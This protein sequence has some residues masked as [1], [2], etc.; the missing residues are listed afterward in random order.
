MPAPG[1][2]GARAGVGHVVR[3]D[4]SLKADVAVIGMACRFPHARDLSALWRLVLDGEVAFEDIPKD[5]WNHAAFYEP[6]D[7]RAADKTYVRKGAF[8]EGVKDFA[9]LHY[10]LAPRR[11]QVTDPQHRLLVEMSRQALQ[12]AGYDKR[13][14][15][16][17]G[18]GVYVGISANEFRD[19]MASRTRAM[20]MAGGDFG[21][22]A[23]GPL[24]DALL[25][26]TQDV[27]PIRAFSIAGSLLN[28]AACVVSQTFDL[29]G[30]AFAVDTACSSALT[31]IHQ[32]ALQLRT[33]ECNLALAGGAYLNLVPDNLVGFARIGAISP[34]GACRP[35]D[36]RADGFVMGEGVGVVVLKRLEDALKDGDRIWAVLKGSGCNN[37]G[38]GEGPMTPRPEGQMDAMAR[39]WR[40][41]D[42]GV[43]SV[44]LV[45]THGT[46]TTVGDVV[47]V[48]ALRQFFAQQ[49]GHPVDDTHCYLSSIK[50]NIGHTMSAAGVA[51]FIKAVLAVHHGVVPPQPGVEELNPKLDLEHSPF[52]VARAATAWRDGAQPRRA[53]V[54][55]FG[56]GGTNVH[57]VLEESPHRAA[58]RAAKAVEREL[59]ELVLVSAPRPE[60]LAKHLRELAATVE[61]EHPTVGE[62]ARTLASRSGQDTRLAF[63]ARNRQE[64]LDGF[65]ACADALERGAPLPPGTWYQAQALPAEQRKAVFLFPG[66]GA[67][68]VG[69]LEDAVRRW[70][71]LRDRLKALDAG[72][73]AET[74][75]S[76][77]DALYPPAGTDLVAAQK[78]L[79]RTEVCQPAM[80]ALGITFAEALTK[81]GVRPALAL[82]HSLGEFTAASAAGMLPGGAAVKLVAMRGQAMSALQL[83][84]AG[85]MLAVMAPRQD[86]APLLDGLE[87]VWVANDNH[88]TQVVLSGT[89][90]GVAKAAA[91]LSEK[92]LKTTPLDVSHAF[93]SP[94]MNDVDARMRPLV[95]ALPV[96]D[97]EVQVVSCITARPYASAEEAREVWTRHATS[98][99]DFVGALRTCVEHG[100]RVFVQVGAGTALLSFARGVAPQG[101]TFLS[102]GAAEGGE[103]GVKLL[104]ALGQLFALGF[105]VDPQALLAAGPRDYVPLPPSLLE[106]ETYWPIERAAP[107]APRATLPGLAAAPAAAFP[108]PDAAAAPAAALTLAPRPGAPPMNDLVALFREQTALLQSHAEVVKA[109]AQALAAL[110]GGTATT[111][112]PAASPAPAL[113]SPAAAAPAALPAAP[114]APKA[115]N[116]SNLVAP[117]AAAATPAPEPKAGPDAAELRPQVLE[118]VMASVA[119]IS[120]FPVATLKPEQSL[121]GELGFDSLMLV[122]LDGDV[123]K[124]W[125][126]LGGLPRELFSKSTSVANIVDHVVKALSGPAPAAAAPTAAQ[127]PKAPVSR[128]LPVVRPAPLRKATEA[129]TRFA[130]PLLVTSDAL[131]V[132]AK[133]AELLQAQGVAAQLGTAETKGDFGG[134]VYT[135]SLSRSADWK[136]P[137]RALLDL[138]KRFPEGAG[139][140]VALTGLGGRFGFQGVEVDAL[141]MVGALGFTKALAQEWPDALVKAIDVD[142][143]LPVEALAKAVVAELLSGDRTAEV[144][145][146]REGRVAVSLVPVAEAAAGAPLTSDAVVLVTGGAKGLGAKFA[147]ALAKQHGCALALSGRSAPTEETAKLL[148]QLKSAGARA[149][150]Y[151]AADARDLE[152]TKKLVAAVKAAHGRVDAVVHCAGVLADAAVQKKD[153]AQVD[154]VLDTKVGGALALRAALAQ[155]PVRLWAF[156]GSWAGRFGNAGQTDYS[157][158]N[159]MLAALA[160][161]KPGAARSVA[162]DFPPWEDSAMVK[163]IPAFKKAELQ[164]QGVT[165]LGDDEGVAAFLAALAKDS[166]E[167]LVGRALPNRTQAH[168][169]DFPLSRLNHVYLNDHQMNGQRVLPLAAAAD[170]CAAA[171]LD[172]LPARPAAFEVTGFKLQRP[173]LVPDTV[174]LETEARFAER[175]G[176]PGPVDV[177]L[178]QDSALSYSGQVR[179]VPAEAPAAPAPLQS[180]GPLPMTVKQFYEGFTFHGPRLQGIASIDAVTD[181]GVSGTVRGSTPQEWIKEPLRKEWTVD[182]LVLDASFQLAGYWAWVKHQ[183]AGFPVGFDRF[184]QY[185]PFGRGPVRCAATFGAAEGDLFSGTL[186]WTDEAG[187]VLARMEG[188]QAEFKKRDPQFTARGTAE[189]APKPAEAAE[190]APASK[191]LDEATWNPALFPEYLELRERIGFAEAF[192]LKNP[193]F[194][195]HEA[196][197][198]DTTVVAGKKMINFSSYNYV[199]NSGDP[200]VSKAAQDAIAKYGTSVSASR[201]ASGEK[202]LHAELERGLARFFGTED[203]IVFTSGHATNVTVVGH[204][205]G[206]GDLIV[207]D[208]LAHDSIIQGAKLSGAKRRPFPHNDFEALDRMLE[209]LR[210]HYRRVLICIEG[211]YSMDGDIP[212]LPKFIEVKKKH[213]ALLLVDEAHSAG[214]IGKTGRGIGEY[215]GVNRAD[216]DLWMGTMSKSFASCGGWICGS[217]ALVEYL[218]YTT[219]GFVYSVGL[220]PPGAAAAL[221]SL[222]QLEKHPERVAKCQQN[223]KRFLQLLQER[224]IDTGMSR[225]SAVVPAIIGNSMMCLQLS[226]R[227]KDRGVN[228]QPILYPAVEEHLARL[229]F[230]VSSLHTDEQL[231]TAANILK[232]EHEKLKREHAA[233]AVA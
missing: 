181:A 212:D 162:I 145:Y 122:E 136:R 39:A 187:R 12:D 73:R 124:A 6:H 185:A 147:R 183:R 220:S 98:P 74:G 137:T 172:A 175:D 7:V 120:A 41:L 127:P 36:A 55:S 86:V 184:V 26:S 114:A 31:A 163:R 5:R 148:A 34:T 89:T 221:A 144:G 119:R 20:M 70:P 151:H 155:E 154:P 226:D 72:A 182:P 91:R 90:P 227:L 121:V 67:Q 78:A 97:A 71:A 68:R 57:A 215:F 166:G 63:L 138:A 51:G 2:W 128:Y 132:G 199:G 18:T 203:C 152:G 69:L 190:P 35:F 118:K 85:A 123:G 108:A 22:G 82:G 208:A 224:G 193:Y 213:G 107:H 230:F 10:G 179:A 33:G 228:V 45:E 96:A 79:T 204:V 207:H 192:G 42:F 105:A 58:R 167:V 131:G 211:T 200:E 217:H 197:C 30:P 46:A 176:V 52:R 232:E 109:Q 196:I 125:P 103:D 44:G 11:V 233:D 75:C 191:Q 216:V 3:R 32:A 133:V 142:V 9:A 223:S 59:P 15:D 169:A 76:L 156:V 19:L 92:G 117:K 209:Q 189:A 61:L 87:G 25:K 77:V 28:M 60:L 17:A 225:D 65:R 158:A 153:A 106:T 180:Q 23:E 201:V 202:P 102:L 219:P 168:R 134:V 24:A 48:G 104:E 140:F 160:W 8:I 186:V 37:D 84:D 115:P 110:Q 47:E 174:W 150:T 173:V 100:A 111:V 21:P 54:S 81:A 95:A 4:D 177:A 210:G 64:L 40:G 83:P 49:A 159:A 62:V 29:G 113:P 43:E 146:A 164:A 14:F 94:L 231:V 56:F 38:R 195:V 13:P 205:V 53:A 16:R 101:S 218:K 66:Q 149:A 135:A 130:K 198:G 161:Q 1:P 88:P 116:F 141:G 214:V 50:A 171:A 129:V 139:C 93:H 157:A 143:E 178:R 112:A 27:V 188:A 229:R 126:Q 222:H 165:F 206:A 194:S 99:V 80:A 170:L